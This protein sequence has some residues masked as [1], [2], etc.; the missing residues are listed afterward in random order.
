MTYILIVGPSENPPCIPNGQR[1]L[2]P[3]YLTDYIVVEGTTI[4][5]FYY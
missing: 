3:N 2:T 5:A 4:N 1:V